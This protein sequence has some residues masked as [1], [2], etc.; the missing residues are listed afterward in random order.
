[1]RIVIELP[2]DAPVTFWA[3]ARGVLNAVEDGAAG[4]CLERL[5]DGYAHHRLGVSIREVDAEP[6]PW[7]GRD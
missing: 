2:D 6:P 1:M 4:H 3:I 5:D 7:S